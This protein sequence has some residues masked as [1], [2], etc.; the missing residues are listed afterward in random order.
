V[1]IET[2]VNV[3]ITPGNNELACGY[4]K[5]FMRFSPTNASGQTTKPTA[6]PAETNQ[7]ATSSLT[8]RFAH[9]AH[10]NRR[11]GRGNQVRPLQGR[12]RRGQATVRQEKRG[13]QQIHR[14]RRQPVR[15]HDHAG[16]EV[17]RFQGQTH[18]PDRPTATINSGSDHMVRERADIIFEVTA[19]ATA[20][21]VTIRIPILMNKLTRKRV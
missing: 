1:T 4:P 5:G 11:Q 17:I 14:Q 20:A 3:K 18:K 9:Q 6:Q 13:Q 10:A 16:V 21:L 15:T 2:C 7:Y 12:V 8:T 19:C